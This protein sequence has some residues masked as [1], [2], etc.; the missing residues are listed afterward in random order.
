[1]GFYSSR[2]RVPDIP[3]SEFI[4][5]E[6]AA[7]LPDFFRTERPRAGLI[8]L[9]ADLYSSTITALTNARSVIDQDTTLAI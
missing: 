9:D 6:F 8:N 5:G 4:A 2:G 3:T 1:M 7:T